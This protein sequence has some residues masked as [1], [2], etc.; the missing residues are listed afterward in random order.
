MRKVLKTTAL[1]AMLCGTAVFASPATDSNNYPIHFTFNNYMSYPVTI[2]FFDFVGTW[3]KPI[4]QYYEVTLNGQTSQSSYQ[5]T[6]TSDSRKDAWAGIDIRK[7]NTSNNHVTLNVSG[8]GVYVVPSTGS[9]KSIT[10][11]TSTA[12]ATEENVTVDILK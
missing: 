3:E 11:V 8:G 9:L 6:L 7:T 10:H 5:N 12:T 2:K 4:K 1:L